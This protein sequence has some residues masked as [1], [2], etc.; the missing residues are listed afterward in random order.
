MKQF[1]LAVRLESL[2]L[3]LRQAL[4]ASERLAVAGVQIDATGDLSPKNLS[5]TGRREFGH[6]LRS[7]NLA[8]A[9]LNC[10]LRHGLDH[11]EGLEG[12]IEHVQ[13]VMSLSF[14]LGARLVLAEAGRL[15]SEPDSP[16]GKLM[17]ESLLTLG[18]YGDRVGA[19]LALETGLD[20]ADVLVEFLNRFDTGGLRV[21][22]NPAN[23]LLN[24][25]DPEETLRSLRD[26]VA[27]F[28][29]RDARPASASKAAQEVPVGHGHIDW[30]RMME[31]LEEIGYQDWVTV[32][33]DS[34]ENRMAGV[35]AG[36]QVLQRLMS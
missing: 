25:F 27:Y 30:M 3:P 22:F 7:Y 16:A 10:P 23:L 31:T 36:V 11:A 5:Q 33:Q 35:S 12:R 32:R 28:Q 14:D 9:A 34:G 15:K 13:R 20:S 6:L 18:R 4:A 19:V 8:L 21:N 1:K 24:G 17:E 2:G 29:A 26:R